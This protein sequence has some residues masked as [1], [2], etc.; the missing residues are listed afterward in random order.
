M[1]DILSPDQFLLPLFWVAFRPLLFPQ[2]FKYCP[3]HYLQWITLLPISQKEKKKRYNQKRNSPF[4]HI[5]AHK[6]SLHHSQPLQ[7]SII[8]TGFCRLKVLSSVFPSLLDHYQELT[9]GNIS[10]SSKITLSLSSACLCYLIFL[11]PFT[12]KLLE[13]TL[14]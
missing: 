4:P 6:R 5:C 3:R 11:I 13:K 2:N 10:G 14:S 12:T 8:S 7:V 9:H 1:H